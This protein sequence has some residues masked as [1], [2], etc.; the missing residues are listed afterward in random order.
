MADG[1]TRPIEEIKTL[2]MVATAEGNTGRVLQ[3]MVRDHTDGIVNINLNGHSHLSCTPEHPILTKRGYV[4]AEDLQVNDWI[5]IPRFK[6]RNSVSITVEKYVTEKTLK[7][8]KGRKERVLTSFKSDESTFTVPITQS[9]ETIQL[10][11]E[12]GRIIGLYLAEGSCDSTKIKWTYSSKEEDLI[13]ET[14]ELLAVVFGAQ[15]RIQIRPNNST[16]VVLYGKH[17]V[18]LFTSLCSTGSANKGLHGD[19]LRGSDE[20]LNAVLEGWLA[21][22]GHY[23]RGT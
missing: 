23:R 8:I 17:W 11:R 13:N 14:I 7:R 6:P 10:T 4:A 9:P 18:E 15:A 12:F 1:S 3:T 19:L 2:D 21:G 16:N 22:D 20:F 5:A